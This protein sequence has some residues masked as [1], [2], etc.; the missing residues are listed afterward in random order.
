MRA[1]DGGEKIKVSEAFLDLMQSETVQPQWLVRGATA[2]LTRG[3]RHNTTG[4]ER[5]GACEV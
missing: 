1:L 4:M 2:K 5:N 3:E